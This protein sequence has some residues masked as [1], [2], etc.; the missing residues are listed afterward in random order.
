L[1]ANRRTL[2]RAEGDSRSEAIGPE[3]TL[4]ARRCSR[5]G[6]R[7]IA[8]ARKGLRFCVTSSI[9]AGLVSRPGACRG[10]AHPDPDTAQGLIL[11][12]QYSRAGR[13]APGRAGARKLRGGPCPRRER[14][15][16]GDGPS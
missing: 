14:T 15:A 4:E 16:P 13:P 8:K 5:T 10:V 2:S 12:K 3:A 1:A 9:A 11:R 7:T 6:A